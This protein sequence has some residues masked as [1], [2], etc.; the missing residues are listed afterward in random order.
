MWMLRG[1]GSKGVNQ[2]ESGSSELSDILIL[3]KHKFCRKRL[4]DLWIPK[5]ATD[6]LQLLP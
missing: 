5:W 1:L 2:R 3:W 4:H 6:G